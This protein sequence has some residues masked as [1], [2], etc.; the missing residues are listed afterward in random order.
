MWRA[1]CGQRVQLGVV[2]AG[3]VV[4]HAW[5]WQRRHWLLRRFSF[6]GQPRTCCDCSDNAVVESFFATL[7]VELVHHATW[8]TRATARTQPFDYIERFYNGQRRHSALG[9][10]SPA[11][12]QWHLQDAPV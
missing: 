4:Y 5:C 10:Q 8:E 9:Y 3:A 6:A 2:T 12:E 11:F 1:S 7:K